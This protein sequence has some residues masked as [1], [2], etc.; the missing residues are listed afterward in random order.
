MPVLPLGLGCIASATQ[1]AGHDIRLLN[2][3][4]HE[5]VHK[6]LRESIKSFQPEA[7]GI[8]VRNIDDQVMVSPKFLLEPV[9]SIISFCRTHTDRPIIIGGAGYSIFPRS[10]LLYLEADMGIQGQGESAFVLLLERLQ[11]RLDLSGVPGLYLPQKGL[12]GKRDFKEKPDNFPMP[13]P[14]E[15]I[16]IPSNLQDQAIWLPFQTRRGCSMKCS[17]C[18]TAVIEGQ[19]IKKRELENVIKVLS[20]YTKAGFDHF[21]FVDNTFNLPLSYA[22]RFCDKIIEEGL[23]ISW[24]CI[25]YPWKIDE[26]LIEK[27]AGAGCAEVS[28]GFES[29]SSQILRNMNKKYSP[30]EV[31]VI[32]ETLRKY[33]IKQTGFLLLG[34]PGETEKTALESLEYA[35]SLSLELMKV[36]TGIRIYPHTLLAYEAA[37]EGLIKKD[38]DLLFP[39]FY[40]S[41]SIGQWLPETVNKWLSN[42]PHW[43]Q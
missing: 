21:F 39:K 22:K 34:G 40:I 19:I 23:N 42:R 10:A 2:L 12:Q 20:K 30:E 35:D 13:L 36:T 32:S 6:I 4:A 26:E 27:M 37:K 9:K 41:K 1:K 15:H 28:L 5:D 11:R 24:R 14:G 25:L 3:M 29:G 33:K 43:F 8:S 16:N 38:E 17:Y 31:R 7:I 18:S